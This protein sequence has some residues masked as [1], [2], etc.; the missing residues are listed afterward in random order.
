MNPELWQQVEA[1]YH[2]A[3]AIQPTERGAFLASACGDD[4]ELR[5]EN[6][7]SSSEW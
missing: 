3:K 6:V 1:L 7:R 5:R 2:S 4:V